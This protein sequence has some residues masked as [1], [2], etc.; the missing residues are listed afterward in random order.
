VSYSFD[1]VI[2]IGISD[3]TVSIDFPRIMERLRQFFV[4]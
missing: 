2:P 4:D 3:G 1:E